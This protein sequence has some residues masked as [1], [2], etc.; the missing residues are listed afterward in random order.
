M[1][2]IWSEIKKAFLKIWNSFSYTLSAK[3]IGIVIATIFL[4][5]AFNDSIASF[6]E[7]FLF[8]KEDFSNYWLDILIVVS[9]IVAFLFI[10]FRYYK[11]KYLA[12][13]HEVYFA[14][15]I[16]VSILFFYKEAGKLDWTFHK[17]EILNQHFIWYLLIPFFLF[18]LLFVF[19]LIS[20]HFIKPFRDNSENTNEF[21]NDDPIFKIDDDRLGYLPIIKRLSGILVTE[22][23]KKSFSV[24]LI[25]PWGN[26]KSSVINLLKDN[27]E[28]HKFLKDFNNK[29]KPVVVHFLPYLNHKEDDIINEF[30][31]ALSDKLSKYN[32]KLSNQIVNYSQK[33][34][35]LYQ[36]HNIL[37]LV[38]K[39][40]TRVSDTPA[41][42]LYDD[43]NKRLQEI[44]KKII[45]FVDDLDRLNDKEI[46]QILKLIRNTA[47]FYNTFFVVAMD[48]QYVLGRLNNNDT[49][50]NSNF[51]DKFF[52]LEVFLPEIDQTILRDYTFEVL[53][54]SLKNIEPT[55]QS[56]LISA[57]N[58][59]D[60]LF[61]DYVKNFRDA[62]RII[63]QVIFDYKNFGTEI[64]LKDFLNF[65][66]FKL[67]FPK[68]IKLLND[69]RLDFLDLDTNKGIYELKEVKNDNDN[70]DSSFNIFK[71]L[72]KKSN[73]YKR[74]EK[75][76]LYLNI[77]SD[78][79]CFKDMLNINCE[80]RGLLIK[81]LA[82]LFGNENP[83]SN[84]NSIR[85]VNNFRMLMQQRIFNDLLTEKEFNALIQY[86]DIETIILELKKLWTTKKIEQLINRFEYYSTNDEEHLNKV[87]MV[88]LQIF[89]KK[90]LFG[91]YEVTV[92]NLIGKLMQIK[93]RMNSHKPED[94][95][96]WVKN[97]I[98]ETLFISNLNKINLISGLWKS[99]QENQ[100][101]RLP[102]AYI[103]QTAKEL[104]NKYLQHL[105][106][107]WEVTDFEFYGVFHDLKNIPT[108]KQHL[109]EN[110]KKF[111]ENN[112]IELLCTQLIE[113]STN[114]SRAFKISNVVEEIFGSKKDFLSL[115]RN[116]RLK[117]EKSIKEFL[118]FFELCEITNFSQFVIFS[119]KIS[120]L[121]KRRI[122]HFSDTLGKSNYDEYKDHTQ[123]V[124]ETNFE[125]LFEKIKEIRNPNSKLNFI[126]IEDFSLK[127]TEKQL[128]LFKIQNYTSNSK[129]FLLISY[130]SKHKMDSAV[131]ILKVMEA[132]LKKE[133]NS[134]EN[135][136]A[137]YRK[138]ISNKKEIQ[139]NSDR[140]L[141]VKSIQIALNK[142][143]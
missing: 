70:S 76:D 29:E 110:F 74:F 105:K 21:K 134:N 38:N 56:K 116:H 77:F 107:P 135:I 83:D 88:L 35:D 96:F 114:S 22:K 63:N 103:Q 16:S 59:R 82:Y 36:N 143:N 97:N 30:F 117:D 49:I 42:E 139:I 119:F 102:D 71:I 52:Q 113:M 13:F 91:T 50:L 18:L 47:D 85:K 1:N 84:F 39:H 129:Y 120:E 90:N 132:L 12:S 131:E 73:D 17:D 99:K 94:V 40:I 7:K 23:H 60:N 79:K 69:N 122:I 121:M 44:D 2:E 64:D 138:N 27:V 87:L 26:G 31:I 127:T 98:F 86:D 57:F 75:Y 11:Y 14:T 65:T 104:Y 72:N 106:T 62:K 15:A 9:S 128:R 93:L 95:A 45:V 46:L 126:K 141:K 112:N 68:F 43:I 130:H 61:E 55:F 89:D 53:T 78:D 118:E 115:L 5:F 123:V 140:Y 25:G 3:K 67:K 10:G 19:K 32:G 58:D 101:W 33:L 137:P 108:V 66:Y 37:G 142:T 8:I 24:G 6:I 80:D 133:I 54:Y 48:K 20:R 28:N 124:F 92:L 100:S 81:T 136:L 41:K 4:F 111:W 109:V 51:V 125:G 34:T